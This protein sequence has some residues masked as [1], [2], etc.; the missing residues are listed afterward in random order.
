MTS[1]SRMFNSIKSN[2]GDGVQSITFSD[3]SKG[4]VKG[5]GKIAISNDLSISNVLLVESLNFNH[6]SVA[7]LC[8]L[9]FKCIFGVDDVEII[10]VD[11]SNLIFKGFRYENIYLVDFDASEGKLS[12]CLLTESSMGWLWHRRLGHVGMK[13]LNKLVKH[14]LVRGLK[15]VIFEKDKVYSVCQVRKQVSNTHPKKSTISTSKAFELLHIDLFGPTTYTSICGNKYDIVIMGYCTRYT[16]VAFLVDKSDVFA[17]FKRFIKRVQNKFE[18]T[19]N[20]VRSDNRTEFKNTRIDELCD[21]YGIRHQFSAKYTPQSNGLVERKNR[22]LIDMAR[23][24]LSE[25]NVSHS[26]WAEAINTA[27]IYNNRLYCHQ[28]LEKTPYEILNSRK[29]NIA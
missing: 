22:T 28:F 18:T 24:M 25:Y 23:S 14:D 6:L 7:Q 16:W 17:T 2:D 9:G 5:L 12:T 13:Q 26:F 29:P 19:I 27:C 1:D 3:N 10:S 15:D 4:K 21:E 20:K 11:G 8:D